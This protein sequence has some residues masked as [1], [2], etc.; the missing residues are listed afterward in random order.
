MGCEQMQILVPFNI[1]S[2]TALAHPSL[3]YTTY[4]NGVVKYNRD[5]NEYSQ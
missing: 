1:F 3:I 4:V 5:Y 2:I